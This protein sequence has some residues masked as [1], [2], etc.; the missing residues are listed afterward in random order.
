MHRSA[1]RH[2][3]LAEAGEVEPVV[4]VAP[5]SRALAGRHQPSRPELPEVVRDEVL[6]L[7]HQLSD[8]ADPPVAAREVAQKLPAQWVRDQLQELKRR[9]VSSSSNHDVDD[10]SNG[11]DM[12]ILLDA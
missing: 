5:I 9:F 11:V 4:G 8:L 2:E 12:S 7:S 6:G 3:E 1:C 10:R